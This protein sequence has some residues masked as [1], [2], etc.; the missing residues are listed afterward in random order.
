MSE[1]NLELENL[2]DLLEQAQGSIKLLEEKIQN[3]E[4]SEVNDDLVQDLKSQIEKLEEKLV[5]ATKETDVTHL[6]SLEA[7]KRSGRRYT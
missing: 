5:V 1:K 6:E 2:N 4:Q 3:S 7:T